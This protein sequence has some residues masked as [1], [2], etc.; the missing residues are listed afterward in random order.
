M[1]N[2]DDFSVSSSFFFRRTGKSARLYALDMFH[3]WRTVSSFNHAGLPDPFGLPVTSSA[4]RLFFDFPVQVSRSAALHLVE[5]AS[6]S[7]QSMHRFE[8]EFS[9]R[10]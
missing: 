10:D 2:R 8:R 9:F 5:G 1:L 6:L 7:F 4:T 3:S